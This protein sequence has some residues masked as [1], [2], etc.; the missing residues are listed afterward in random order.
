MLV[1]GR[2]AGLSALGAH[3]ADLNAL[4]QFEPTQGSSGH[5]GQWR[6]CVQTNSAA[7]QGRS[8]WEG[9]IFPEFRAFGHHPPAIIAKAVSGPGAAVG[10]HLGRV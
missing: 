2:L 1:A 5:G 4:A 3:Y 9:R 10:S 7:V 6:I 8:A